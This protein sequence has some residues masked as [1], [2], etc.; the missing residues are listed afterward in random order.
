VIQRCGSVLESDRFVPLLAL[1][2]LSSRASTAALHVRSESMRRRD[3]RL[4]APV[5]LAQL[6]P[7]RWFSIACGSAVS[8]SRAACNSS[9]ALVRALLSSRARC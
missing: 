6:A 7:F 3:A 9:A 2:H 5:D 1:P 4:Q 8:R